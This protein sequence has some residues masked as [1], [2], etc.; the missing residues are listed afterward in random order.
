MANLKITLELASTLEL[1]ALE[2]ALDMFEA[3]A[4]EKDESRNA[5]EK[6]VCKAGIALLARVRGE[7]V[8]S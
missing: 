3:Y 2:S 1:E 4:S 6:L 5:R 8:R 7:A